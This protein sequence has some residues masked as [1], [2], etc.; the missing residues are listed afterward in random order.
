MHFGLVL[1]RLAQ[2]TSKT[3]ETASF[4]TSLD[5]PEV[6]VWGSKINPAQWSEC[7]R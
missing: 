7:E 2:S 1:M 6:L 4:V 3:E 5:L